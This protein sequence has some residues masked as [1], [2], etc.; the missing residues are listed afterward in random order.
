[1]DGRFESYDTLYASYSFAAHASSRAQGR[2]WTPEEI[3]EA[4]L[5]YLGMLRHQQG[6]IL[7]NKA[8]VMR[9]LRNGALCGRSARAITWRYM[10]ISA[11]QQKMNGVWVKGYAPAKN[12]GRRNEELIANL[13]LKYGA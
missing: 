2:L 7:F 9:D 6:G 3:E 13:L 1:M 10:N 5:S 12:V 4:V 8:D 11:V